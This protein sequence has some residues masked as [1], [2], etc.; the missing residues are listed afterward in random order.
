MRGEIPRVVIRKLA[1][2]R[3]GEISPRKKTRALW[4]LAVARNSDTFPLPPPPYLSRDD[5]G[6]L[7]SEKEKGK[8]G[9]ERRGGVRFIFPRH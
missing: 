8:G 3:A 4:L 7:R 9:E 2:N 6:L 1:E 5:R